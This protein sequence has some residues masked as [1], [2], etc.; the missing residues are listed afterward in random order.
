MTRQNSLSRHF[1]SML[2]IIDLHQ[3]LLLYSSRPELYPDRE[4]TSF[5]K[6]KENNVKVLVTSTFVVPPQENFMHPNILNLIEKELE[7]YNKYIQEHPE[8]IIIKTANDLERVM[9]SDNLYG[10]ILHIEGLNKFNPARDWRKLEQWFT[11]GLR[12]IG[13]LWNLDNPFGG[14]THDTGRGLTQLGE[15][16]IRW[17]EERGVIF[18]CAHMNERTFFEAAA[19]A[20]KPVFISHG[21]AR[22]LCPDQRNY[23]DQQLQVIKQ[24]NGVI[25]LFMANNFLDKTK[26]P[27]QTTVE[28]HL[29]HIVKVAGVNGVA[30]GTDYGGILSGCPRNLTS[31]EDIRSFLNRLPSTIQSA[32]AWKNA[33]RILHNHLE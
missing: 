20:T 25:G 28:R 18:D 19:L 22:S 33:Y 7:K 4:Q 2:P 3:D 27:D 30:L 10:L 5:S 23:S 14:G 6:L 1:L 32:V 29:E 13:P 17:C 21:N 31:I 8:F 24:T 15:K 26:I 9:K 16:L 12:S 11:M